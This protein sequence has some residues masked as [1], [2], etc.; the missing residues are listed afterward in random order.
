VLLYDN[1]NTVIMFF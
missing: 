1:Y